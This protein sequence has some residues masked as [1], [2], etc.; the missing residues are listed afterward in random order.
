MN[1]VCA[2]VIGS[3]HD[4]APRRVGSGLGLARARV[5]HAVVEVVAEHGWAGTS[6]GTVVRRARVSRRTF[7]E[8]FPSGLEDALVAVLDETAEQ[9]TLLAAQRLD[10]AATWL[11][12]VRAA[13]AALLLFFDSDLAL[14]RVCFVEALGGGRAAVAR[15]ERAVR[16]F[17]ALIVAR[18]EREVGPVPSLAA[19][20]VIAAVMGILYARLLRPGQAEG[21]QSEG[22]RDQSEQGEGEQ[23][24]G[25]RGSLVEL[26]GPLMR[27]VVAPY[28]ASEPIIV[29]EE[30]RGDELARAIRA[31]ETG[32]AT[33]K[34]ASPRAPEANGAPAL[35]TMLTNPSVRR[36]RECLLYIAGQDRQGRSP[37]NREIAE[38]IGI[39][40][41]SQISRLLTRL[42]AQDLIVKHPRGAGTPNAW[43]LTTHGR[44]AA[45][46][47]GR[48]EGRESG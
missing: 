12:G 15:R 32:W 31:G 20:S 29:E 11:E 8:L 27:T 18:V 24:E 42:A 36:A 17:R 21:R 30:R 40:H 10:E 43:Q 35:P 33:T 23:R 45:R 14:A 13:L 7:Y 44:Q 1:R 22:G 46:V 6:V 41:R 48:Q 28:A 37:N 4:A 16:R 9:A 5:L 47:L 2:E 19:E 25:E 39:T 34:A 26:L 38:G 3:E